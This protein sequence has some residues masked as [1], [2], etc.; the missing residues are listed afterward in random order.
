MSLRRASATR[1]TRRQ[2]AALLGVTPLI[3]PLT[4]QVA[5][6]PV[7]SRTPPFGSPVPAQPAATPEA[8]LQRAYAD[9]RQIS[10]RL[11][12]LEVPMNVEPAFAFK[13]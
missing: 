8:R 2:V 11:Q 9:I 5:T 3:T 7:T 13:P 6:P 12:K 4:A 1:I 10:D